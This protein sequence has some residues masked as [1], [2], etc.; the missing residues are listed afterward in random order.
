MYFYKKTFILLF[1]LL[2]FY[3]L[4]SQKDNKGYEAVW[5]SADDNSLPQNSVKS[6]IKD[7]NG[8]IWMTTENGLVR[9]DGNRFIFFNSENTLGIESNR[10]RFFYGSVSK[11]SLFLQNDAFEYILLISSKVASI[12]S[13]KLPEQ[14]K[15]NFSIINGKR[16]YIKKIFKKDSSYY[17]FENNSISF[18]TKKRKLVWKIKYEYNLLTPFFLYDDELYTFSNNDIIKFEKGTLIFQNDKKIHKI[19]AKIISN[20]AS[21]QAFIVN[22]FGV[23]L[24]GKKNGKFYLETLL[25]DYDLSKSNIISAY[26][27]KEND[28]LYLGSGTNGVLIVK[29]KMFKSIIGSDQNGVYYAQVPYGNDQFLSTTGEIFTTSTTLKDIVFKSENDKYSLVIDKNKDI[30]TKAENVV[31]QFHKKS[32]FQTFNKWVFKD[33]VTQLF[34]LK[35]G[36]FIIGTGA[37][38]NMSGKIFIKVENKFIF[39]MNVDFNPTYM[40]QNNYDLI[41][42]G[43]NKGLY[44]ISFNKKK[45]EHV[46]KITSTYVRSI[47]A[48][49]QNNI[50]VTTYDKGFFL[51]NTAT[52]KVT[53]FPLDKNKYL[54]SSH[55]IVEDKNGFFWISTNK[56]LFQVSKQNLI[57]Y[58]NDKVNQV[59]YHYYDRTDGFITNEFNGGCQPCGLLLNNDYV[60][61]PSMK[62]NV[63]FNSLLVKP[64]LPVDE[65]YF[66]QARVN[67]KLVP[68]NNDKFYLDQGFERL[69]IYINSPYYGNSNNLNIEVKYDGPI[70]QKW[71]LLKDNSIS[72]T[73]L[74]PGTYYLTARKLTG[75]N[76]AYK[77][78]KIKIVIPKVFYQTYWFYLCLLVLLLIKAHYFVK[79]RTR[80]IRRKNVLL[81]K[82]IAEQT[83]QLRSTIGTLK[84]TTE[85]LKSEITNHKKLIGAIT[86]DIKSPLR[87]LALTGKHLYKNKEDS[88]AIKDDIENIYSSSS[89]LYNFVENL[90]EYTKVS[91]DEDLSEPYKIYEL[92][93]E[94]I[95]I[96]QNIASSKKTIIQNNVK[97]NETL[98]INKQLLSIIVHNLLD[99]AV[100]NTFSGKIVFNLIKNSDEIML[101]IEDT[102]I[103]MSNSLIQF[104]NE[105]KFLNT[106]NQR[107]VGMGLQMVFELLDIIKGDVRIEQRTNSGTK[108]ILLFKV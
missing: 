76:S 1:S 74:P 91:D 95:M 68:I 50:W 12:S 32:N 69:S 60:T 55:C 7:K 43:S 99:N 96:F 78:K 59:Y 64:K 58:S 63:V 33:R 41:W 46:K 71:T 35:D 49:N 11:D 97:K 66:E 9:Y 56:G 53:S 77:Y 17:L 8:F 72:F 104:Y 81:E 67:D 23:Q 45:V 14:F 15:I 92:I 89:Q 4:F 87:F 34:E 85:S 47:Y 36:R 22:D 13:N 101:I 86:H 24:L 21:Q 19:E 26:Y 30:W 107:N 106:K 73:T 16:F 25:S 6:I 54:L 18:Y 52:K 42:T 103:G 28:I 80:Y 75:F 51:Y 57:N 5:H 70:S 44:K 2:T 62:G 38:D 40:L 10:M 102:G 48:S 31:Y 94:K 108:I 65:I 84:K 29:K 100:K 79:L 93:N 39:Y 20:H 61:F 82:K 98:T 88:E 105:R 27:D 37:E 83:F 3:S 90:L